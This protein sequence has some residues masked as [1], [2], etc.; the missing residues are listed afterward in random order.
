M[1]PI[2]ATVMDLSIVPKGWREGIH[3]KADANRAL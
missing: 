2:A 1:T 3:D